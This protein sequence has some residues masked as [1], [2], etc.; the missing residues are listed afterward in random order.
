MPKKLKMPR[1]EDNLITGKLD[2][3]LKERGKRHR[4]YRIYGTIPRLID[5]HY[6]LNRLYLSDGSNWNDKI[7]ANTFSNTSSGLKYYG[8]CFS[9]S[10]EESVA[11]WM[12]YGGLY[13]EGAMFNFTNKYMNTVVEL[14]DSIHFGN[15]NKGN[16]EI[17]KILTREDYNIYLKDVLYYTKNKNGT[18]N[19][20][21][22]K[23]AKRGIRNN[24]INDALPAF[25]E[26]PWSYENE[27]RLIIEVK[28]PNLVSDCKFVYIDLNKIEEQYKNNTKK[29]LFKANNS[30]FCSPKFLIENY[31]KN[32]T[33]YVNVPNKRNVKIKR[34]SLT[35]RI[36]WQ[37]TQA[38]KNPSS[39]YAKITK[40][41][42]I[43]TK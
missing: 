18:Y 28:D 11:M 17:K 41:K 40:D 32:C 1:L 39:Y 38:L 21:H 5:N 16:F 12:L 42:V 15:F 9:F 20:L 27:V 37:L 22:D 33:V 23:T 6:H 2:N 25:K 29:P 35:G 43:I 14:C 3:F 13:D 19:V 4:H 36:N 34:S 10:S 24:I 7:D 26:M 8:A 30:L 31:Y